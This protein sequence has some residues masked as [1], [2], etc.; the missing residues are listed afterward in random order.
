[1]TAGDV[2]FHALRFGR[3]AAGYQARAGIQARM[4]GALLDLWGE[5]PA[6]E[7]VLEF[8]CGTGLLTR[9]LRERFPGARLLATDASAGMLEE[10]RAALARETRAGEPAHPDFVEQDASGLKPPAQV[11]AARAPYDLIAAGAMVQWFPDLA[12]HFEFAGALSRP[13]GHYL[14][15]GFGQGNFPELNA[16]LA[17]PPFSYT[18]FPGHDPAAVEAAAARAGWD[19]SAL[20][21]WEEVEVL[22]TSRQVLRMLQDLGSV[23]DPREGGRMN[24][25]NLAWLL[26]EYEKRYAVEGGVSITWKPWVALLR[27]PAL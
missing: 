18:R 26:E 19:V 3:S 10:A 16:L 1:M 6:P 25:S 12:R 17:G 20:F 23:R 14:V 22:P 15:S 21:A 27:Q 2:S 5:R 4:A 24:R 7:G 13:G 11:V 9:G 8:G